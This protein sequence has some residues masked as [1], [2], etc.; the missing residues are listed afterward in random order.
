M[1]RAWT[2]FAACGDPGWPALTADATP[3]RV[4]AVPADHLADDRACAVRALWR[5]V[6]LGLLRR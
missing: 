4:W 3:V 6:P 2:D 1:L 5:D